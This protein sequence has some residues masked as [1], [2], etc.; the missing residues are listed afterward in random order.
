MDRPHRTALRSQAMLDFD[1]PAAPPSLAE[2]PAPQPG[3]EAVEVTAPAG[4]FLV[5]VGA[6]GPLTLAFEATLF[7]LLAESRYPAPR[8]RRARGGAL[9]ARLQGKGAASCYARPPGE[10]VSP[11][12]ATPPQLLEVGRLLARLHQLGEAHPASVADP[13]GG[14][15]LAERLPAGP[16]RDALAPLLAAGVEALPLGAAHGRLG[17]GQLLFVG[18][19]ASGVL[20]GGRACAMPLILDL[21]EAALAWMGDLAAP[22]P[23]LRAVV[24]GYQAL[25]RLSP[26]EREALFPALR[27]AAAREGALLLLDG[28]GDEALRA[29]AMVEALGAAEVR[30][31]AG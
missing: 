20:P 30:A 13:L 26:E 18:E 22:L 2:L 3:A 17:P 27:F 24:S 19:R 29:L 9:I 5:L 31:A 4:R 16:A 21:A 1:L 28:R 6:K 10:T 25:R 11:A 12:H 23:A 7:D 15:E 8:P 14:P